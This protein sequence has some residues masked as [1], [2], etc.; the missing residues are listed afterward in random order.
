MS[1]Y[2][3][4]SNRKIPADFSASLCECGH[5][6]RPKEA[7][8]TQRPTPQPPPGTSSPSFYT[9]SSARTPALSSAHS[10][11]HTWGRSAP[12]TA[13]YRV[14][15]GTVIAQDFRPRR[16]CAVCWREELLCETARAPESAAL[17]TRP[18]CCMQGRALLE[19]LRALAGPELRL[20]IPANSPAS[21]V[22]AALQG[23]NQ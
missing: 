18:V 22:P 17:S 11:S 21:A 8:T 7:S 9:H 23:L 1:C 12:H 6:C 10:H 3:V 5:G 15:G 2:L 19:G 4:A 13:G 16:S 20:T 14:Q